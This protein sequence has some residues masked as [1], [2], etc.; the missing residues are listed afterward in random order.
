MTNDHNY[1]YISIEENVRELI[2]FLG[3]QPDR[4]GLKETP[5]RFVNAL[6]ELTRGLREP[7]PEIKFFPM[8]GEKY[9]GRI[10][11]NDI[12]CVKD[13]DMYMVTDSWSGDISNEELQELRRNTHCRVP[14]IVLAKDY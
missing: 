6:L 3:D 13:E 8:E 1:D 4:P 9:V 2:R 11:V 12:R 14:K 5:R 7:A 10:S